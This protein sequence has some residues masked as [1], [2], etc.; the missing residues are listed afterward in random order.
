MVL[1]AAAPVMLHKQPRSLLMTRILSSPSSRLLLLAVLF[2]FGGCATPPTATR[3]SRADAGLR[4]LAH[5]LTRYHHAVGRWPENGQGL[6]ALEEQTDPATRRRF[7]S[8]PPLD[9][10]GNRYQYRFN[11]AQGHVTIWSFGEDVVSSADDI[12]SELRISK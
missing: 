6:A 4:V 1:S 9:P 5:A 7:L 2:V 11:P 3:Q 12:R 10:W 8:A